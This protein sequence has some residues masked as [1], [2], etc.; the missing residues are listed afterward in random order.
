MIP[1]ISFSF[2]FSNSSFKKLGLSAAS[3]ISSNT[4]GKYL[5]RE[6]AKAP[7]G[8]KLSEAPM[9]STSSSKSFL[10]TLR[11]PFP[12]MLPS[13]LFA[14]AKSPSKMGGLSMFRVTETRG[15]LWFSTTITVIPFL[16][17]KL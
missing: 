7:E 13:R 16:R 15:S 17:V 12:S 6:E 9:K 10:A 8:P 1:S 11:D 5:E 4:L 2:S 3:A 14:P